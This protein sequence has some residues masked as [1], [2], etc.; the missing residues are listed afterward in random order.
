MHISA[1]LVIRPGWFLVM[2]WNSQLY[3]LTIEKYNQCYARYSHGYYSVIETRVRVST[4]L[5]ARKGLLVPE[6]S[7]LPDTEFYL[8]IHNT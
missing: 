1:Y 4:D 7:P 5:Q 2:M 6:V 8:A 3:V